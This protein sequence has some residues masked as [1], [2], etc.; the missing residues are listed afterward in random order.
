LPFYEKGSVVEYVKTKTDIDKLHMV[1]DIALGLA[2]LHDKEVVHGD[3]RGANVLIDEAGKA[4]ICD[5]GLAFVIEPSEFTSIKTAGA[6]RWTAP[7][8]MNPPDEDQPVVESFAIFTKQ[9]D[10]YSL[11]MTIL[12]IFT[13]NIPFSQKK[14]D[15]S[16]IF[17]VLGG[18]R[19]E[20]PKSLRDQESLGRLVQDCWAE[21]PANRPTSR[22]AC[23]AL[24][25]E[26]SLGKEPVQKGWLPSW[27]G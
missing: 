26:G 27:F 3:L 1:Q 13:G 21:K 12:E 23:K 17:L 25:V 16:V 2:Y 7:E 8:I 15:S 19:P 11:G 18:G 9:S 20:L 10:M 22:A 6:C 24:N 5:V 4:R 14:N